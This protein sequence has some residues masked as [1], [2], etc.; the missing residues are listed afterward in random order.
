[1]GYGGRR[2]IRLNLWEF[3]WTT[4]PRQRDKLYYLFVRQPK[5]QKNWLERALARRELRQ[6]VRE[7]LETRYSGGAPQKK[8]SLLILLGEEDMRPPVLA[9]DWQEAE[10]CQ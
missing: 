1:M 10:A 8:N 9:K 3:S 2:G 6:K 4:A 5:S 7:E